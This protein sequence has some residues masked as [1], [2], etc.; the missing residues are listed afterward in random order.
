MPLICGL[1][2]IARVLRR[3]T[4]IAVDARGSLADR[5]VSTVE[6]QDRIIAGFAETEDRIRGAQGPHTFVVS[7]TTKEIG[8]E[9]HHC[10][11]AA[12]NVKACA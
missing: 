3:E 10:C 12:M 8:F 5:H 9:T 7:M 4:N 2:E 11:V 1:E 6:T